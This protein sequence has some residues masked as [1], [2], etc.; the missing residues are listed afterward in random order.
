MMNLTIIENGS[1]V[2]GDNCNG[3]LHESKSSDG[4]TEISLPLS[5]S[6]EENDVVSSDFVEKTRDKKEDVQISICKTST[7]GS[8]SV[9]GRRRKMEDAVKVELGFMVKGGVKFDFYG[10]YDGHGGS[11]VAEECKGR[12]HKVLQKE[13][14]E[15]NNKEECGINWGRTMEKC[16]EKMEEEVNRK[17]SG[18]RD[19]G[20]DGDCG[21]HRGGVAMALSFDHKPDSPDEL[22]RVE[23][24]GGWVINWN[25]HRV[26]G[27]I[28]TSRSIGDECLKPFVSC[29][30]DVT[31]IEVTDGDE[32]LILATDGLWDVVTNELA[33][34]LVRRCLNS[35]VLK[36]EPHLICL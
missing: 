32:F 28:A 31:V 22:E 5:T 17:T 24:A 18:G 33:C 3:L 4:L 35:R 15:D 20:V 1:A 7:H 21:G 27:V 10:V 30:P 14:V 19:G 23:A 12:L 8:L 9:I 29:K 36:T 16:F 13:I 25:G 26:L 11:R 2:D 6:S 34:R